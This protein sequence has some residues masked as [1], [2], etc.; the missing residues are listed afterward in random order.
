M[1]DRSG[2]TLLELIL[3]VALASLLM[4]GVLAVITR[5]GAAAMNPNLTPGNDQPPDQMM[6]A[7][8]LDNFVR[9]LRQ[10]LNH[11]RRVETA[12]DRLAIF[13]YHA[14][15]ARR[16]QTQHRPVRVVYQLQHI[17]GQP[18]LLR[19]QQALDVQTNQNRQ[20]DL[21][22]VGIAGF[23]LKSVS[24]RRA[25]AGPPVAD[26]QPTDQAND[27]ATSSSNARGHAVTTEI[28]QL[29]LVTPDREP[30]RRTLD[31]TIR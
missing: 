19:R 20:R 7:K 14:L 30:S 29:E 9:L 5:I 6:H 26:N 2:F 18:W 10:D 8:P 31:I 13:T 27:P 11:A 24:P 16:R 17:G 28:W 25:N 4:V 12:P 15:E 3:A 21:L 23:N 1:T 22:C